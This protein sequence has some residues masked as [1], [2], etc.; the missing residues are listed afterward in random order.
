MGFC[1]FMT[2]L[3]NVWLLLWVLWL[4]WRN[5]FYQVSQI[6]LQHITQAFQNVDIQTLYFVIPVIS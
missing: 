2:Y 6:T 3:Y 1:S 5:V 4:F